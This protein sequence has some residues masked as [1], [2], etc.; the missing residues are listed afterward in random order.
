MIITKEE[1]V[2]V[3]EKEYKKPSLEK[4]RLPFSG[5]YIID[6]PIN[7]N[8]TQEEIDACRGRFDKTYKKRLKKSPTPIIIIQSRVHE[9]DDPFVRL[10]DD[11][12]EA[13][14]PLW[15]VLKM[16]ETDKEYIA[17]LKNRI[18]EEFIQEYMCNWPKEDK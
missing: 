13:K 2:D 11:L 4:S 15:P 9:G 6:D 1:A 18:S 7:P 3:R 14:K 10:L 5:A 17:Q 12:V 16:P 8:M